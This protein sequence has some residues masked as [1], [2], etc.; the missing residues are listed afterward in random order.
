MTGVDA[1]LYI[2]LL[3]GYPSYHKTT[4]SVEDAARCQ[5]RMIDCLGKKDYTQ[6]NLL[7]CAKTETRTAPKKKP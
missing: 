5:D 3:C 2:I 7:A 1:L 4:T 6:R